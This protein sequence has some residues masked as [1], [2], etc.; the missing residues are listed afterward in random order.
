MKSEGRECFKPQ[1]KRRSS[2]WGGGGG[3]KV[4]PPNF[5]PTPIWGIDSNN[6]V[7]RKARGY[8]YT[9]VMMMADGGGNRLGMLM[10]TTSG[11]GGDK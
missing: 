3:G 8:R 7:N 11:V 1:K 10:T 6:M 5:R 4:T 2:G 9:L